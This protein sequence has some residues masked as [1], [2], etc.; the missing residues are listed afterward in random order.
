M[1]ADIYFLRCSIQNRK[2]LIKLD[3]ATLAAIFKKRLRAFYPQIS[4]SVDEN[5]TCD[6]YKCIT[7]RKHFGSMT[8]KILPCN[9]IRAESR[10]MCVSG[11][12]D[13]LEVIPL[14]GRVEIRCTARIWDFADIKK[15]TRSFCGLCCSS[16][17]SRDFIS[18]V[19][20]Y[21]NSQDIRK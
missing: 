19:I 10:R 14:N 1:V 12:T 18:C 21:L 3:P 7:S 5:Y 15:F 16:I 9:K 6:T 2:K 13:K 8:S 20:C 17:F 11:S 4:S